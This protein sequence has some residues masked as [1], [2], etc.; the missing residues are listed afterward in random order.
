MLLITDLADLPSLSEPCGLTIGSFDGVHLGHQALLKHLK[1]KL[2]SN[3]TLAVFTFLNHP[4]HLFTPDQPALLICPPLQKVTH[5]ADYGADIV[6]LIPFTPEFAKT[7]F[8]EFLLYLK[9][10]LNFSHLALGVGAT[11]G[12]DKEGDESNVQKLASEFAFKVDYIPKTL[13]KGVPVSS[14]RIRSSIAKGA[15]HEVQGCLG[16]HYS[17]MGRLKKKNGFFRFFL[18]GICL[19]PEG[20]YPVRIREH[21]QQILHMLP[22]K[23]SATSLGRVQVAPKEQLIR[24]DF[25]ETTISLQDKDVEVIF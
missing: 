12:K 23:N 13:V 21:V 3:G 18:P 25:L 19:P 16:R 8:R 10:Q 20:I 24:L 9:K 15:L 1:S 6:C 2:P 4:T 14:G 7:S 5:L 11:F 17:L 22:K